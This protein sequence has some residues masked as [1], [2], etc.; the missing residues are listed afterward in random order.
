MTDAETN[1]GERAAPDADATMVV[2]LR[3][4]N[5][6][7]ES[8]LA[9]GVRVE[10]RSIIIATPAGECS[11]PRLVVE[12]MTVESTGGRDPQPFAANILSGRGDPI[13]LNGRIVGCV[14]P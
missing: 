3:F 2:L 4:R 14:E 6:R 8:R 1:R 11:I 12:H 7:T 10:P 13:Y 9:K 5:G